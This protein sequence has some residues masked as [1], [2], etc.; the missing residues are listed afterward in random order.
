MSSFM[1]G[2]SF[3]N[4]SMY[5]PSVSMS[6]QDMFMIRCRSL[7]FP[8]GRQKVFVRNGKKITNIYIKKTEH[9]G[10][11]KESVFLRQRCCGV[12]VRIIL[13]P[14]VRNTR[15][16]SG[17]GTEGGR[18][19]EK[20][21][22]PIGAVPFHIFIR[23]RQMFFFASSTPVRT[24][25]LYTRAVVDDGKRRYERTDG[26]TRTREQTDNGRNTTREDWNVCR[27]RLIRR[28]FRVRR[29]VR[30]RSEERTRWRV[31]ERRPVAPPLT[32]PQRRYWRHLSTCCRVTPRIPRWFLP[33]AHLPR[34]HTKPINRGE[35]EDIYLFINLCTLT[36]ICWFVKC[37]YFLY[38]CT[39]IGAEHILTH[40]VGVIL[41]S[42]P[43][44]KFIFIYN[45][46]F[47]TCTTNK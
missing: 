30:S 20:N 45:T 13:T 10:R 40:K 9:S 39:F 14:T 27:S 28:I 25:S 29:R 16:G 31:R 5:M 1:K 21:G 46:I 12:V 3:G 22:K 35:G 4:W 24:A 17:K 11:L 15:D 7:S 32:P 38:F 26:R 23:W 18:E 34:A 42:L 41:V 33:L 19:R 37:L 2:S 44:A 36:K 6:W 43:I 8:V 47:I